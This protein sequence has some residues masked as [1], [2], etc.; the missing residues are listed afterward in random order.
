M[1]AGEG[2]FQSNLGKILQIKKQQGGNGGNWMGKNK[3]IGAGIKK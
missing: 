2:I 3:G 1:L